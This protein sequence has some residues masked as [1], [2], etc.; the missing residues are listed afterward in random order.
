MVLCALGLERSPGYIMKHKIAISFLIVLFIEVLASHAIAATEFYLIVKGRNRS[1]HCDWLELK[2]EEVEC[3][4][5][6]TL[7]ILLPDLVTE[8]IVIHNDKTQY[9]DNITTHNYKQ[10]AEIVNNVT[11]EQMAEIRKRY[12]SP[13]PSTPA[14]MTA[15]DKAVHNTIAHIT[16][17]IAAMYDGINLPNN[18]KDILIP[19]PEQ[20]HLIP[21]SLYFKIKKHFDT[22]KKYNQLQSEKLYLEFKDAEGKLTSNEGYQGK[23]PYGEK[24]AHIKINTIEKE[25]QKVHFLLSRA[26]GWG[27]VKS[28]NL[29]DIEQIEVDIFTYCNGLKLK[30]YDAFCSYHGDDPDYS[31]HP[32]Y[33]CK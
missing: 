9:F 11:T 29:Q 19:E 25:I 24:E 5:N 22:W 27:I 2:T 13:K 26:H 33:Y 7:L 17:S 12:G 1:V 6:R 3:L 31:D 15:R 30:S 8:I 20:I 28:T 10:I 32:H 16:E 14:S 21:D 18:F 23:T 4:D